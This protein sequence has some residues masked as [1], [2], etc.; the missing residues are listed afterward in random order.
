MGKKISI[1]SA[2]M[3]NKVF[4]IIEAKK[5]FNLN[6]NQLEILVH[7]K[8][9]LHAIVKFNNGLS[10]LLVHDT[11]MAIPIFNSIYVDSEKKITSKK[12]NIEILNNLNLKKVNNVKFP[13]V[14]IIKKLFEK[15]SL[16][17]TI[18]VSAND[19]L[20]DLFLNDKIKFTD[21]SVILIKI[22]SLTEFNKF[23]L[24]APKNIDEINNLA[25]YVSLKI[26]SLGI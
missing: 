18:V 3:M 15:D 17:E 13:V 2:T 21:I 12:I 19:K 4:E 1:D 8:S 5:I 20:V 7:P 9:Y 11:N 10:K 23:K 26:D 16:F 14:K 25:D 24:I 6:Y 22:C